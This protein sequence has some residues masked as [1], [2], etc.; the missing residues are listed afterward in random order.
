MLAS[1]TAKA[2]A[3]PQAGE[4]GTLDESWVPRPDYWDMFPPFVPVPIWGAG[5]GGSDGRFRGKW[6]LASI[7]QG[8]DRILVAG[9]HQMPEAAGEGSSERKTGLEGAARNTPEAGMPSGVCASSGVGVLG[10]GRNGAN[11]PEMY[12]MRADALCAHLASKVAGDVL[13][14]DGRGAPVAPDALVVL[15]REAKPILHQGSLAFVVDMRDG[16]AVVSQKVDLG[17]IGTGDGWQRVCSRFAFD[18]DAEECAPRAKPSCRNC[19]YR[20]WTPR[21]FT[22]VAAAG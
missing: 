1:T 8:A 15:V 13:V 12:M 7:C 2:H 17:G 19:L 9:A 20:R 11:A 22:C 16:V 6:D 10:E 5:L 18:N 14:V 3:V 21:G 4:D